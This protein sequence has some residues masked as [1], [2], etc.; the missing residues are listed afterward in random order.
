MKNIYILFLTLGLIVLTSG[1][2]KFLNLEYDNNLTEDQVLS[3]PAKAEGILLNAYAELPSFLNLTDVATDN[4][5]INIK[6]HDLSKMATG[7]WKS[8]NNPI[9][10]WAYAYKNIMYIN[11]FLTKVDKVEWSWES[12]WQNKEFARK[13]RG[14]AYGLRAFYEFLLLESHAGKTSDGSYM[15]FPVITDYLT[16][17]SNWET[18]KRGTY[19]EC[20]IQ[21]KDDL[22]SAISYLPV[23]Y[24]DKPAGDPLKTDYDK[25]YGSRFKNRMNG[26]AVLFLKAKLYLHAASPAFSGAGVT[27]YADAA[28]Q[29]AILLKLPGVNGLNKLASSR[30]EF[31]LNISDPD[32][33]WRRDKAN[34]TSD[35]EANNFPPSLYGRGQVNPSQNF[36]DAFPMKTGYP[37]LHPSSG[38]VAAT[39]YLNRDQRLAK[40][41]IYNGSTFKSVIINTVSDLKD[42]IGAIETSTRSGY[43]LKKH[44]N[45]TVSLTPGSV[46][47]QVHFITLMRYTEAFLMYAESANMAWGPN[48]D[49]RANGF[50]A[51][52]VIAKIR[53]TAGITP[54]T[55]LP[56]VTTTEAMDALIRNERRLE[57]AFE[58]SRFWDIRRWNDLSAMQ[59][60]VKGTYDGGLT[61]AAIEERKY[62]DYMIYGPVPDSEVKK[63]LDQNIGW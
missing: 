18:I 39:P 48:G 45:S 60:I 61:S 47:G 58:G 63:G 56:L 38:F 37:V 36:V 53:S 28:D 20:F 8:T 10:V 2:D 35:I 40:Y 9:S 15:G 16:T 42:G 52:T 3:D 4:A 7:E 30:V 41:V 29:A 14:E 62:S 31:Y 26:E 46:Q 21:I 25:V 24:A 12:A 5:V 51:R 23:V 11:L 59:E 49:P 54:D 1:C 33:L 27:T 22:D 34:N 57:L 44:L 19:E 55:Y 13:L 43:Y 6:D 50:T 17:E 32:I